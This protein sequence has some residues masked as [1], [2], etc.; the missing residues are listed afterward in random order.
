M[1]TPLTIRDVLALLADKNSRDLRKAVPISEQGTPVKSYLEIIVEEPSKWL[2]GL[3]FTWKSVSNFEHARAAVTAI[4]KLDAVVSAYPDLVD[5][6]NNMMRDSKLS[7]EVIE[8]E[9]ERRK[10]PCTSESDDA[11]ESE[12]ACEEAAS[13]PVQPGPVQPSLVQPSTPY[14]G[15]LAGRIKASCIKYCTAMDKQATMALLTSFWDGNS[16]DYDACAVEIGRLV[17]MDAPPIQILNV[18]VK[19]D[20]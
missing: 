17:F 1:A 19:T 4:T 8:A 11:G 5:E 15:S 16:N 7:R 14:D 6:F 10:G 18:F 12:C 13:S 2:E 9:V 20:A 3:P